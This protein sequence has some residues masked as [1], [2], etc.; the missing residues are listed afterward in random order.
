MKGERKPKDLTTD[1]LRWILEV[2]RRL[3]APLDLDTML[4][5]VVD[6]ARGVCDADFGMVWLHDAARGELSMQVVP[7]LEP[8]RIAADHGIVGECLRLRKAINLP[9]CHADPRF[10]REVDL[11]SGYRTRS[12]LTLPMVGPDDTLVGALQI[13]N[14]R[15]G[16]FDAND[17]VVAHLLADQCAV[18]LQRVR[19]T[20][21]MIRAGKL[22]Q[23]IAVAREIQLATLPQSAPRVPGYDVA[24]IFRPA[25]E[26]GGDTYDFVALP[27]GRYAIL[28]GDAT[29][30]GIG[31]AL[32]ATHVRAMLRVALR[33]E[34]DIDETVRHMNNQLVDDL[35][36]DR[37]VT[38][39]LGLLD[40]NAHSVRYHAAGQGPLLH[41]RAATGTCELYPPT[42]FP[43][44]SLHMP[45][46]RAAAVLELAPGDILALASDGIYEYQDVSQREFG[47]DAVA[48]LVSAHHQRP[49]AELV[50]VMLRA[51]A[52]FGAGIA[53]ADDLSMV[54]IRR[55]P[56]AALDSAVAASDAGP[57]MQ[58]RFARSLDSLDAVFDFVGRYFAAEGLD[59]GLRYAVD[60]TVE[61]LFANMVRHNAEGKSDIR[62]ALAR[63]GEALLGTIE[64]FDSPPFDFGAPRA[65]SI[66]KP[67]ADRRPGGLGLHLIRRMMDSVEYRHA[68]RVTTIT[69][70]KGSGRT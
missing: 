48:A 65:T 3:A 32:L 51:L 37:F 5:E 23:E 38:A 62:L 18:A 41:F 36:D 11:A 27:G 13:V 42:S 54:L 46:A 7:G 17:E 6:V 1:E 26:T 12:M 22:G 67:L 29:G 24:G 61:E 35:P 49:M 50:E 70:R 52:D 28:M 64:D 14:P 45:S 60:L 20:E 19:M 33:L 8:T 30:H 4:R 10:D 40:A 47:A 31:P 34:A 53:Q 58:Q 69:F 44:G 15:D 43:L 39:F 55:L 9:D 66:G 68:D 21:Q 59:P 57:G 16:V 56:D 63:E 25:D 2:T